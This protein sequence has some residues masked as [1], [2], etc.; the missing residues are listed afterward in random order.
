[1]AET[2]RNVGGTLF[3]RS[4]RR[5]WR[6]REFVLL[7]GPSTG[8]QSLLEPKRAV[9]AVGFSPRASFVSV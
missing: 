6:A 3:V 9:R 2:L 8:P 7:C 4:C 5:A 1:M